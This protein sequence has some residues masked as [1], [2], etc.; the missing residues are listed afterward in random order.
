MTTLA[1]V[2]LACEPAF[3][4]HHGLHLAIGLMMI[5]LCV[6]PLSIVLAEKWMALSDFIGDIVSRIVLSILYLLVLTPIAVLYRRFSD[7]PSMHRLD[8]ESYFVE[9][10]HRYDSDDFLKPW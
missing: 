7:R 1:V 2:S 9:R 8:R 5:G 10:R 3:G 6:E 4:F